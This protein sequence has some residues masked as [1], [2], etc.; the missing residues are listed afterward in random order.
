MQRSAYIKNHKS[1]WKHDVGKAGQAVALA[2]PKTLQCG[3]HLCWQGG[4]PLAFIEPHI[5]QSR[6]PEPLRNTL[7]IHIAEPDVLQLWQRQVLGEGEGWTI[8]DT[9][10]NDV[11]TFV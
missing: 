6:L 10:L 11:G 9:K 5:G 4:E 2:E 3:R 1:L 7:N 8:V